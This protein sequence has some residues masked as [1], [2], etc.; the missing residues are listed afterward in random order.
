MTDLN[1]RQVRA[2]PA[3]TVLGSGLT[4]APRI[5]G[6]ADILNADD[7]LQD[8]IDR[9]EQAG[10]TLLALPATGPSTRLRMTRYDCV[11]DAVTAYGWQPTRLRP[12]HPSNSAIDQMDES[13]SWLALIPEGQ[14]VIRRIVGARALVHPI[15]LRHLYPWRRLATLLGA[16]HKSIQR[17]HKEGLR[18]ILAGLTLSARAGAERATTGK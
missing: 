11:Q 15:T 14:A 17:W 9:L 13:W 3:G 1:V 8:L 18:L 10:A 6:G 4:T 12:P 16:D 7:P 5:T 2:R